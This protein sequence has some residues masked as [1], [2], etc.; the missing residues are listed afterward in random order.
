MLSYILGACIIL[1]LVLLIN[2]LWCE[3]HI[4][5]LKSVALKLIDE[6]GDFLNKNIPNFI[7][8]GLQPS[9]FSNFRRYT[10]FKFWDVFT[11]KPWLTEDKI[12]SYYKPLIEYYPE[13][14]N[15]GEK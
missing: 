11:F 3:N 6:E 4:R 14:K 10:S 7:K 15:I 2:I 5:F 9:D 13:L 1:F 8:L 12:R